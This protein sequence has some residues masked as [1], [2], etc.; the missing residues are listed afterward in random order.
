[1]PIDLTK[2]KALELPTEEIEVEI[3]GEKQT[4]VVSAMPMTKAVK[5]SNLCS[6]NKKDPDITTEVLREVLLS[7]AKELKP[8]EVDLLLEY[9]YPAAA[10]IAAKI[11]DLT[12]RFH[13]EKTAAR[14]EAEKNSEAAES[15]S[16]NL[17]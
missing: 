9:D 4:T 6:I 1:M 14:M 13:E 8:E 11:R 16:E 12:Q 2:L 10:E 5:I 15:A 3:L 17:S 7:G